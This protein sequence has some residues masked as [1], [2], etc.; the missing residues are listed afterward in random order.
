MPNALGQPNPAIVTNPLAAHVIGPNRPE[1]SRRGLGVKDL[2][3]ETI[4]LV[5]RGG[6]IA[7]ESFELIEFDE[8][9]R[10]VKPQ[11]NPC[12]PARFLGHGR[13]VETREMI[14]SSRGQSQTEDLDAIAAIGTMKPLSRL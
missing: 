6:A 5:F 4:V 13:V 3:F 8:G 14:E 10:T 1:R 12:D 2:N 11:D 9:L 7:S